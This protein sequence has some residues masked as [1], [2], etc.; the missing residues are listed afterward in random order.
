MYNTLISAQELK[1]IL[2]QPN[3]VIIDC[4]FFLADKEKGKKD[5]D[6]AHIPMAVYAHLDNDL[7]SPIIKGKTGR[8]PLLEIDV[9][10]KK[11]SDWGI[12]EDSQVIAYDQSHGGVAARL[13]FLLK[14]LGHGKVAV[15]NG[16]WKYWQ[17]VNAPTTAE[18]TPIIPRT[19]TPIPDNELMVDVEFMEQNVNNSDFIYIDS[20]SAERYSGEK[21]PIDPIAGHI[22]SALSA[23]FLENLGIDG[24]FLNKTELAL[25]FLEILKGQ[26]KGKAVFYCGS[27][28]TACHNLLAM[29]H[30]GLTSP[31]LFPGSW[32]EW[33]VDENRDIVTV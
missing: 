14:W 29:Y 6:I 21:E 32:S 12:N 3:L 25:R 5:Y 17:K 23:P 4:R 33:I 10:T 13:W 9:F 8:H 19:F 26:P 20:R 18:I 24:L 28:V 27:G 11:L 7:S 15:L 30:L 22:P 16:G 31:M 2:N 1:E